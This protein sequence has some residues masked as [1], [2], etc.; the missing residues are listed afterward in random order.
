[1]SGKSNPE[2]HWIPSAANPFG[3]EL[4]D[5]HGFI[6]NVTAWSPDSDAAKNPIRP[7]GW[8]RTAGRCL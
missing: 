3:V 6:A 4:L 7:C 8:E 5:L 2:P 1:V